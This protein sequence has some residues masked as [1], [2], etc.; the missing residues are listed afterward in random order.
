MLWF[1]WCYS[2]LDICLLYVLLL[3]FCWVLLCSCIY[4]CCLLMWLCF[5]FTF[6]LF[7]CLVF[8]CWLPIV[9]GFSLVV[10]GIGLLVGCE[11]YLF[12]GV[13]FELNCCC[14]I[15][16]FVMGNSISTLF[17]AY[18]W[19]VLVVCVYL[20]RFWFRCWFGLV[21]YFVTC[22]LMVVWSIMEV[23]LLLILVDGLGLCV[24]RWDWLDC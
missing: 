6:R 20:L 7:V 16:C 24:L 9:L 13:S 1:I 15:W 23:G 3:M 10:V 2:L 12:L 8:C 14:L 21:S 17:V 11:C 4:R 5:D 18:F 22:V 19:F